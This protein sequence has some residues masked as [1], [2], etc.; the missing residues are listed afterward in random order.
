MLTLSVTG[1]LLSDTSTGRNGESA[2]NPQKK[3]KEKSLNGSKQSVP[4]VVPIRSQE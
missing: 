3:K 1:P 4:S 2:N